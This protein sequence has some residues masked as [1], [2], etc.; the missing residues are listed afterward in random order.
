[1]APVASRARIGDECL[2]RREAA[3]VGGET[4]HPRP[5]RSQQIK[6]VFGPIPHT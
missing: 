5:L 2:A 1:L 4:G 3:A 6:D